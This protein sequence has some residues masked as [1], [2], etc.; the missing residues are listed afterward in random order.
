MAVNQA[1]LHRKSAIWQHDSLPNGSWSSSHPL[2][3]YPQNPR[4]KGSAEAS[5][6]AHN[7]RLHTRSTYAKFQR[8]SNNP[9]EHTTK[10][11]TLHARGLRKLLSL[12]QE[13]TGLANHT[14]PD[15]FSPDSKMSCH[16]LQ[17]PSRYP[18]TIDRELSVLMGL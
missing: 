9:R 8:A 12:S 7:A 17:R 1:Q 13:G 16:T 6:R 14:A 10:R 15:A 2:E 18:L 11:G 3:L 4:V 5:T